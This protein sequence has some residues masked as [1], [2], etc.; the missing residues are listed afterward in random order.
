MFSLIGV[1][2]AG[3]VNNGEADGLRRH[4]THCDVIVMYD[5]IS[6]VLSFSLCIYIYVHFHSTNHNIGY[7]ICK[8][9]KYYTN[10]GYRRSRMCVFFLQICVRVRDVSCVYCIIHDFPGMKPVGLPKH[11]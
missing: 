1:R 10:W 4:R 7:H 9:T 3:R 8:K 2:K 5:E 11:V 6:L